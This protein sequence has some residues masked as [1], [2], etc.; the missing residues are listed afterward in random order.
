MDSL[1]SVCKIG[2]RDMS[3]CLIS[4]SIPAVESHASVK[5]AN[6]F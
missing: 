1:I 3:L 6:Y 4:A 2:A 5:Y